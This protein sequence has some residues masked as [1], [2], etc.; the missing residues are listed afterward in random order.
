MFLNKKRTYKEIP[1]IFGITVYAC[2]INWLS[3]TMG[4]IPIDSFGWLDTGFSI[5]KNKLPIRDF[6]IFTGLLVDYMEAFFLFIFGN[7]WSSHLL[8]ASF[9]NVLMSLVFYFFLRKNNFDQ[10]FSIFYT[11]SLATLCYPVSG[12]PFAYIHS[13]IF[14]LIAIFILLFAFE[15]KKN[16]TWFI[17]PIICFFAFIS[18]QTPSSYIIL[19]IIFFSSIYFLKEKRLDNLKYFVLGGLASFLFLFIFLIITNT[20]FE[21]FLYQ[22]ILFPLT[23]GEGRLLNS[24]TA[25]LSL[26]DQINFKRIFGDFKFIHFVLI[27][28]LILAIK[29]FK[30]NKFNL[31]FLNFLLISS[32]IALIFNQLLTA[33]Q[34][35]IFSLIPILAAILH[36]NILHSKISKH[37]IWLI[38]FIVLFATVKFHLRYNID[39]KFHE[40]ENV[41]KSKAVDA[42]EIHEDLKGLQWINKLDQNPSKEITTIKKA[43]DVIKNDN[44]KKILITHYQFFSTILNEDLNIL[45]RWY[46]WDN[47]THPTEDHKYFNIYKEMVNKNVIK[48]KIQVIYLLGQDN[49]FLFKNV[50]NYFTNVCFKSKTLEEKRFSMHELINC[51]NK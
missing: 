37:A 12:T 16:T 14:S 26:I 8:H 42:Y 25:Y 15:S 2:Y 17:L 24:D 39:R 34:I 22:Y 44:R 18:M 11:I 6:W 46:L 27:P 36:K 45:N 33:N 30:N 31:N 35:F 19:L 23:I 48:N 32:S 28:L 4:F 49:D 1:A 41:D 13:Y 29:N 40:L 3:G 50:K 10:K 43:I 5:L 20:P 47:N 38:I 7:N 21:N 9:M 51:E